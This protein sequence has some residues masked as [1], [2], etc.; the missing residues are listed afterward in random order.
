LIIKIRGD[1]NTLLTV[2]KYLN[3][4]LNFCSC[5]VSE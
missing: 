2:E 3:Q 5:R 4:K 1:A